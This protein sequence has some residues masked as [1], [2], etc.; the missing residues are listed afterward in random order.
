[1]CGDRRRD[2]WKMRCS[3]GSH[4]LQTAAAICLSAGRLNQ[5]CIHEVIRGNKWSLSF[6]A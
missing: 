6:L 3:N 4:S 2:E 1:M 5:L